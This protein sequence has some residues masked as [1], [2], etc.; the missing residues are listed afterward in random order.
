MKTDGAAYFTSE[1]FQ[2]FCRDWD[3][4]HE[5]SS[6][7]HAS[8]NGLSEVYVKIAKRIL[9]KAKDDDRDPYLPLLEYRNTPLKCGYSP[10]QLLMC[11]RLRSIL[12]STNKQLAPK[13]VDLNKARAKMKQ[14]QV[15]TKE[16]YDKTA[17]RLS[18]LKIGESVHI[19]RDK[20]WEPAKVVSQHNEHSYNVRTQEGAIYRRNRK[21]LNKTSQRTLPHDAPTEQPRQE[22]IYTATES[23]A[24]VQDSGANENSPQEP[25][26]EPMNPVIKSPAKVRDSKFSSPMTPTITRSDRKSVV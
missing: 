25:Q 17:R 19:Q 1:Q 24:N 11:R 2:R 26:I 14:L 16:H 18:P 6:P 7:T 21:F 22:P 13:T 8:S 12:P 5:A 15:K 4:Q 20:H 9:Q 23:S 3:I 10:A